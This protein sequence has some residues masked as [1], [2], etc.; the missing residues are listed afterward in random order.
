MCRTDNAAVRRHLIS[1]VPLFLMYI[2]VKAGAYAHQFLLDV[3]A[4]TP[5]HQLVK[6]ACEAHTL[7]LQLLAVLQSIKNTVV[8]GDDQ[9]VLFRACF[10]AAKACAIAQ[11]G[12][13]AAGVVSLESI[14]AMLAEIYSIAGVS[15]IETTANDA[16]LD[17]AEAT[18]WLIGKQ[19]EGDKTLAELVGKGTLKAVLVLAKGVT[20]DKT[21]TAPRIGQDLDGESPTLNVCN[22]LSRANN[23]MC[24]VQK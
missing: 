14:Q 20:F 9:Q 17:A 24:H 13:K 8:P 16:A 5:Y 6:T 1:L 19:R 7:R 21:A 10:A 4:A 15:H 18:A 11:V 12:A 3:D 2:H 22:V 23:A